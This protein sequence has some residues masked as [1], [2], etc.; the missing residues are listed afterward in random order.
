M[1]SNSLIKRREAFK[2]LLSLGATL[3]LPALARAKHDAYH[4]KAT[5]MHV[6]D[7][8]PIFEIVPGAYED[9][10]LSSI[11]Q[12]PGAM[13]YS[14]KKSSTYPGRWYLQYAGRKAYRILFNHNKKF[15]LV[16]KNGNFNQGAFVEINETKKYADMRDFWLICPEDDGTVKIRSFINPE[17]LMFMGTDPKS[18]PEVANHHLSLLWPDTTNNTF[19]AFKWKLKRVS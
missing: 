8:D 1:K 4:M 10:Y 16:I 6:T 11:F 12:N 19:P 2:P 14:V 3:A 13:T 5:L 17:L 9:R 15:S 7:S 18:S